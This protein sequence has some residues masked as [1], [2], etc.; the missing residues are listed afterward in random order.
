MIGWLITGATVNFCVWGLNRSGYP[1]IGESDT[2][3]IPM[4]KLKFE[5]NT[6]STVGS[7]L[8]TRQ[9]GG[10]SRRWSLSM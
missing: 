10:I 8:T 2:P 9:V 3:Q 4:P 1:F 6:S 5:P 7:A